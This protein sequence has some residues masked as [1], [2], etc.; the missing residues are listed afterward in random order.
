L[1]HLEKKKFF[2]KPKPKDEKYS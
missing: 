1:E 2:R